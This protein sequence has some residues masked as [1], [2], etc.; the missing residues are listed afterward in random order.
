MLPTGKD[1]MTQD[2]TQSHTK[3]AQDSTCKQSKHKTLFDSTK[4]ERWLLGSMS[5]TDA[6]GLRPSTRSDEHSYEGHSSESAE[7]AEL[8]SSS[9]M[10]KEELSDS[11]E[12]QEQ[13]LTN[14]SDV[15]RCSQLHVQALGVCVFHTWLQHSCCSE[16]LHMKIYSHTQ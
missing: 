16:W 5:A 13:D 14:A 9:E 4:S 6:G 11:S 3:P 12:M 2:H 1:T 15:E 7:E 10:E 8:S